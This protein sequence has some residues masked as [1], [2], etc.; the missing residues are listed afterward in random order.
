MAKRESW[1]VRWRTKTEFVLLC[2]SEWSA[3]AVEAKAREVGVP[4][5]ANY[6]YVVRK[7]A[8]QRIAKERERAGEA[9]MHDHVKSVAS[10][11]TTASALE[12]LLR[13]TASVVGLARAIAI[14]REDRA[15]IQPLLAAD[16]AHRKKAG[17][18]EPR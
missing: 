15:R 1:R 16:A 7:N 18:F 3:K 6:V 10:P 9:Q 12:E 5:T 13:A 4:L 2:P 14:I 17:H 11:P 8:H